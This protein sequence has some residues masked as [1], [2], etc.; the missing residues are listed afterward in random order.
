MQRDDACPDCAMPLYWS[1]PRIGNFDGSPLGNA[2]TADN[3]ATLNDAMCTVER[4]GDRL[5]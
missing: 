3:A 4:F 1:N 2:F 5:K